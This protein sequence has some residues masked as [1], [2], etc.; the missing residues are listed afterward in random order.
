MNQPRRFKLAAERFDAVHIMCRDIRQKP[1]HQCRTD[2]PCRN[3][4]VHHVFNVFKQVD[5]DNRGR[6]ARRIRQR[7]HFVAKKCARNN[8]ARRHRHIGMKRR[9]HPHKGNADRST[10][11]QAAADG[12]ADNGT[13][14]KGRKIKIGRR[15]QPETV[16]HQCGNRAAH[17]QRADHQPNEEKQVN[18]PHTLIQCPNHPFLHIVV[19]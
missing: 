5:T 15:N 16:I 13:Q 6:D 17:H 1:K 8:R 18:R 14:C 7:G 12:H 19:F 11:S 4:G 9:R 10:S 2:Q 3:S